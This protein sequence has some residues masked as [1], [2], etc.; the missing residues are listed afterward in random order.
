[1]KTAARVLLLILGVALFA[2]F[3]QQAN[4]AEIAGSFRQLGWWAAVVLI[5]YFFVYLADTLGWH[6]A[7]GANHGHGLPFSTLFRIRWAGESV[8]NVIPTGYVGGE[9]VKVYLLHKRGVSGL[10]GASAVVAG[11]TLQTVG[12]FLFIV[13]GALC[14][15]FIV[16][17]GGG[18][19][20][21]MAVILCAAFGVVVALFWI[22][23]HGIFSTA[24]RFSRVLPRRIESIE[25]HA[26]TFAKIDRQV[27]EF[28]RTDRRRF[29]LSLGAYVTG[30]CLDAVEI[31]VVGQLMG[32]PLGWTQAI[33]IEAFIGVAKVMGLFVPGAIGVQESGIVFLCRAAGLPDAFG[34][35]YAILRRGR[36]VVFAMV[37]WLI[38]YC[39]ESSIRGLIG[40]LSLKT[41][42]EL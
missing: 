9:A 5:P 12:Q 33:A 37:G 1:M 8:N 42:N 15:Y 41:T 18:F 11:R 7:F 4:P 34:V 35:V 19:R 3:L 26:E 21:G 39:E 38:L 23:R 40:R 31:F 20:T 22:Q 24:L 28:Y 32:V 14:F 29:F 25:K 16:P 30:F 6:F 17:P 2:W 27:V 36:E 13:S 10:R